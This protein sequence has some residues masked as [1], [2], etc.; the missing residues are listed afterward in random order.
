MLVSIII[1]CY[2]VQSYIGDCLKS[3]ISQTYRPIEIIAVDNNSTDGTL[4]ILKAYEGKHPEL[5]TILE[6]RKQGAPAARNKGMS[7]AKGEW[8]QF[9]DAD[10][11]LHVD[12]IQTQMELVDSKNCTE[13]FVQVIGSYYHQL[14]DGKTEKIP[15]AK[16]GDL[17]ED[18]AFTGLGQTSANLYRKD[19]VLLVSGWDETLQNAQDLDIEYKMLELGIS[20]TIYDLHYGTIYRQRT[21][22]QITSSNLDIIQMNIFRVRNRHYL[23]FKEKLPDL[24][25]KYE[26]LFNDMIYY[27]IYCLGIHNVKMAEHKKVICLGNNYQPSI[28]KGIISRH[29]VYG[30]SFLGFMRYMQLRALV[31]SSIS[32]IGFVNFYSIHKAKIRVG[33]RTNKTKLYATTIK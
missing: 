22:G 24:F 8:L 20:K 23:F 17:I 25:L 28:R 5:I 21:S 2:N 11:L 4:A 30:V 6:E 7:I 18:I 3:A 29:H 15:S 13:R 1:P 14:L 9:L 10:D 26:T 27:S 19:S 33:E 32:K 31:K 16:S 12:K